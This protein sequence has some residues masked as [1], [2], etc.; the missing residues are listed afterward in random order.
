MSYVNYYLRII[1]CLS[2]R[3]DCSCYASALSGL[4][5]G[6]FPAS[7]KSVFHY[8]HILEH[9]EAFTLGKNRNGL[10]VT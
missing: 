4:C 10:Q 6:G 5:S 9:S 3:C 1:A 2:E 8:L 7:M